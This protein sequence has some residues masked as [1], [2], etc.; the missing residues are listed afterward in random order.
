[1]KLNFIANYLKNKNPSENFKY[2]EAFL[3]SRIHQLILIIL[4]SFKGIKDNKQKNRQRFR[5][6]SI[7]LSIF[8]S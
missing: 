6:K 3:E 2:L 8:Q 5:K 7:S 4:Y 1:M